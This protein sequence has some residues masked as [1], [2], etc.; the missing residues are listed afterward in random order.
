MIKIYQFK[1]QDYK[2]FVLPVVVF[3]QLY[4]NLESRRFCYFQGFLV[5]IKSQKATYL[6]NHKI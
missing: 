1:T 6:P 2:L 4:L 3:Y 5:P